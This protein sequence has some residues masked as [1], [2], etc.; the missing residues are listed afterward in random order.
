MTW[1][2][3]AFLLFSIIALAACAGDEPAGE[4]EHTGYGNRRSANVGA[5]CKS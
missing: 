5:S 3:A 4:G 1:L 2:K